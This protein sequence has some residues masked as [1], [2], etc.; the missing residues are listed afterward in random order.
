M[1][2]WSVKGLLGDE[3]GGTPVELDVTAQTIAD[4]LD[5]AQKHRFQALHAGFIFW[6]ESIKLVAQTV[7]DEVMP[8]T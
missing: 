7:D 8:R 4:A 6:I 2:V 1:N 5:K 3:H